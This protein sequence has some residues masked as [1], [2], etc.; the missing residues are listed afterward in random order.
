MVVNTTVT[1]V[2]FLV[3]AM[4]F[5]SNHLL[6]LP[7]FDTQCI[8]LINKGIAASKSTGGAIEKA[9][10]LSNLAP[11]STQSR[12]NLAPAARSER[13]PSPTASPPRRPRGHHCQTA[14]VRAAVAR[15]CRPPPHVMRRSPP[16]RCLTSV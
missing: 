16:K 14:V 15:G 4:W 3:Q 12:P 9:S 10:P 2:P 7:H 1:P 8:K 13:P 6:Q 5:H 11:I